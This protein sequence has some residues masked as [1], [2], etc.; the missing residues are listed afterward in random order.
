MS[1]E[2]KTKQTK[3]KAFAVLATA[4]DAEMA[5]MTILQGVKTTAEAISKVVESD[6]FPFGQYYQ[7]VQ[8][9]SP[10]RIKRE[11]TTAVLE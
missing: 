8:I 1:D 3:R 6:E 7:V 9:C 2:Q 10:Q 4:E 5:T 11:V